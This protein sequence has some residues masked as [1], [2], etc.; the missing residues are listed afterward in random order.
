M[1]R[2]L[3]YMLGLI[4]VGVLLNSPAGA[5]GSPGGLAWDSVTK[6][7]PGT[8]ASALAPGSFDADYAAA[9][10]AQ[11]QTKS[12][13]GGLFA[14]IKQAQSVAGEMQTLMHSGFAERHYVAGSKERTDQVAY[15]TATIVDCDARTITQLDLR[16]KTYRVTSMDAPAESHPA[17]NTPSTVPQPLPSGSNTKVAI[18]LTNTA[19]GSQ[20]VGGEPTDG[21]RSDMKLT[22]T[23]SSGASQTM[24]AQLIGYY[25]SRSNPEPACSRMGTSGNNAHPAAGMMLA[26]SRF[27]QVLASAGTDRRVTLSQSGPA[28]PVGRLSMFDAATFTAGSRGGATFVTE[29][30][31]VRPVDSN[32]PVFSVPSDFT[33]QQQQ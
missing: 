3:S 14:A 28:L 8:D 19:L 1:K 24:N 22:T 33:E 31:N 6:F 15:Q 26:A 5:A 20:E 30:G 29:R 7:M 27:K 2:R 17:P 23:D 13:G 16:A 18:A 9:S 21:F 4:A 32:D 12:G 11:I 10:Q 25:S